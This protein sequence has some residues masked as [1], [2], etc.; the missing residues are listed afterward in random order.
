MKL[1]ATALLA[2][3]LTACS[4][5]PESGTTE[6]LAVHYLFSRATTAVLDRGAVTPEQ[7]LDAVEDAR[8]YVDSGD[9]VTVAALYDAAI[10]RLQPLH[11]ADQILITAILDNA[12]A[13]LET[14]IQGGQLSPDERVALLDV[15]S[16]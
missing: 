7:V 14:A 16:W 1:I 11:P 10:E 4:L 9:S 13:R 15:L 5:L 12:R 8:K 2:L 6:S 3:T